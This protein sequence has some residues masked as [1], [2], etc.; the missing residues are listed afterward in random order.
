[1][2]RCVDDRTLWLLSEGD[3]SRESRAHVDSCTTCTA[4]LRRLEQ[5]LNSLR[6]ALAASPPSPA[7]LS[8][9][10]STRG[11]WRAST[12]ALAAMV[13]LAW[14]GVWWQHL[15]PSRSMEMHQESIWPFIEGVSAALFASVESGLPVPLERESDFDDL[16]AALADGWLCEEL[17]GF[18]NGTCDEDILSPLFEDQ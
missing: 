2:S 3:A 14:F 13:V 16:Q 5:D 10:R 9:G 18:A 11:R 17:S 4:R 6:S 7:G 12:A 8:W 1:M 15:L